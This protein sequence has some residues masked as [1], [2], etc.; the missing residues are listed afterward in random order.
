MRKEAVKLVSDYFLFLVTSFLITSVL[1]DITAQNANWLPV[2]PDC[3][4]LVI[5]VYGLVSN[6]TFPPTVCYVRGMT[7]AQFKHLGAVHANRIIIISHAFVDQHGN[8]FLGTSDN[9]WL[10]TLFYPI[11][12][13]SSRFGHS[14][15]R[16]F[17]AVPVNSPFVHDFDGKE[18][19]LIACGG[20][21][22][23][24]NL[25]WDFLRKGARYVAMP[26]NEEIYEG[27]VD[28]YVRWALLD[29][30]NASIYECVWS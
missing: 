27:A 1:F 7:W 29:P 15:N 5:D 24:G 13:F 30:C 26:V 3:D 12:V 20:S 21:S 18:I 22:Y 4:T 10:A 19:V 17:F 2:Q 14:Y 25:A 11:T 28:Y 16:S 9:P 23:L 8:A 6:V